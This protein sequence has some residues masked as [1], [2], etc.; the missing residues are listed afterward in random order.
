MF[1]SQGPNVRILLVSVMFLLPSKVKQKVKGHFRGL[2]LFYLFFVVHSTFISSSGEKKREGREERREG[3]R[4]KG[5]KE[6]RK[7]ICSFLT[8]ELFVVPRATSQNSMMKPGE[9][10]GSLICAY[11]KG[12]KERNLVKGRAEAVSLDASNYCV[13]P[14]H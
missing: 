9:E 10:H 8:P 1:C 13:F 3:E 7:K 6:E 11:P 14:E 12:S 5:R 4:R 2:L